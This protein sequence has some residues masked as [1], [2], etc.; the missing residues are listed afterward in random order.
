MSKK[1]LFLA[2]ETP[3]RTKEYLGSLLR[4]VGMK[5][6]ELGGGR[7]RMRREKAFSALLLGFWMQ[8][9]R[10]S[11]C[12]LLE[13]RSYETTARQLFWRV[14]VSQKSRVRDCPGS[15]TSGGELG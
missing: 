1:V 7:R 10:F 14:C 13:K 2:I 11:R 15:S 5:L 12:K 8:L 4:A 6:M 9:S 3:N